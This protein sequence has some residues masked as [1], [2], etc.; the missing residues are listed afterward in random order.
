MTP[1][2]RTDG[3]AELVCSNS[4]KGMD[5][6]SAT[7]ALKLTLAE[8]GSLVLATAL[9]CRVSA[10]S[11]LAVDRERFSREVTQRLAAHPNVTIV[12][13][14]VAALPAG[15]VIVAT[16]PMTSPAMVEALKAYMTDLDLAFY[17]AAA[18]IV[19]A[20]SLDLERLH[21][22]SRYGKG[23]ADYLNS[24]M[25]RS[26]YDRFIDALLDADR[27]I[28]RE[29]ENNEL[30]NACQPVEQVARSGH[31]AL[32]FGALKPVGL[33]DPAIGHRPW[34]A[35]QLRAENAERGA[36]NLVGFQT[37]LTFPAQDRVFRMIPG[38]EHAEFSRY[39]VM[40]RNTFIDAPH[41]LDGGFA[42]PAEPRVHFAGQVT[43]T[44]GYLEAVASGLLAA[45]SVY[46]RL[47]GPKSPYARNTIAMPRWPRAPPARY[48]RLSPRAPICVSRCPIGYPISRNANAMRWFR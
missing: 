29:F 14:E 23:G 16:G 8:M 31:D 38:L 33:V 22:Q 9:D 21:A 37:N 15:E 1:V 11:A 32:R 47:E 41:V 45:L 24:F 35:V 27:V 18:P 25:D 39:G 13:G 20:S 19:D 2:H 5:P 7:G 6:T 28:A 40:H 12:R 43:G 34:A 3:F 44:E 48:A 36:Y 4:F 42:L 26:A 46:A 10:G 17:D 30:F